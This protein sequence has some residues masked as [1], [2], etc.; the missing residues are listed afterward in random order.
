MMLGSIL[1]GRREDA[2]PTCQVASAIAWRHKENDRVLQSVGV[3]ELLAML[4]L[5]VDSLLPI[6]VAIWAL[7]KLHQVGNGLHAV[8][9]RLGAIEQLLHKS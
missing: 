7:V 5:A 8:E 1:D 6:A 4:M 9:A 3:P 2:A